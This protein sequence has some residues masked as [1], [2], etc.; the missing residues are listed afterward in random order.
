V[1][2]PLDPETKRLR[3]LSPGALADEALALKKRI[4]AIKD[5]AIRRRL[6]TAE[7]E[8]GRITLSP[9][10]SQDRTERELLLKVL[11]ITEAEFIARFTRRV[12]T[13]WRLTIKPRRQFR[14][15]AGSGHSSPPH[16]RRLRRA[17][18]KRN[19]GR[20]TVPGCFAP[21]PIVD[22]IVCGPYWI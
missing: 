15:A 18:L 12:Q 2:A 6:K 1:T 9:P 16:W 14:Q 19:G 22:H 5:E 13:D 20:C 17:A 3:R 4:D 8:A 7:G 21:A 11:D 10:G